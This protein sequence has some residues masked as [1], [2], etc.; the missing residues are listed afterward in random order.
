MRTNPA[1][2]KSGRRDHVVAARFTRPPA[3]GVPTGAWLL[4]ERHATAADALHATRALEPFVAHHGGEIAVCIVDPP[5]RSSGE[6]A[7]CIAAEI[8]LGADREA[9]RRRNAGISELVV[10]ETG[11]RDALALALLEF[12]EAR[13][14]AP[15]PAEHEPPA[16]PA[17]PGSRRRALRTAAIAVAALAMLVGG[18]VMRA[19]APGVASPRLVTP[20]TSEP[21]VPMGPRLQAVRDHF[22]R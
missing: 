4:L 1:A 5:G 19:H 10:P 14:D 13:V 21:R 3:P 6:P 2:H 9:P 18:V 16:I 11:A 17:S 8:V 12:W 7:R 20:G 15:P 22:D